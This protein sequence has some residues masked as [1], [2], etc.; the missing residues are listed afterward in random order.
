MQFD[1]MLDK[2]QS[3]AGSFLKAAVFGPTAIS[4]N[5]KCFFRGQMRTGT[6]DVE[7]DTRL[8]GTKTVGNVLPSIGYRLS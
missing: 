1:H 4:E 5:K 6:E 7:L 3:V 8:P 2:G